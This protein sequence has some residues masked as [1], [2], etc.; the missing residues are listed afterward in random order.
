MRS[1]SAPRLWP[2]AI[3]FAASGAGALIVETVWMRWLRDWL[4]ATAPAAAAASTAYFAGSALGAWLGA[5][6]A[7]RL[8]DRRAALRAYA[9][10]ELLAALGAAATPLLL[11]VAGAAF[12]GG[13]DTLRETRSL[14]VAARFA[15]SLVVTFPAAVAY[16]ATLPLIGAA[17][18]PSLAR[19]G[20]H[21]AALYAANLVGAACGVAVAAWW[22]PGLLGVDGTYAIGIVLALSASASAHRLAR[23]ESAGATDAPARDRPIHPP[24]RAIV[25]AALSGFVVLGVQVLLV[26]AFALVLHRP[27]V[28]F[29]AVL[30]A[31][32]LC[33]SGGAWIVSLLR[34][35]GWATGEAIAAWSLVG[36]A[37]GAAAIPAAVFAVTPGAASGAADASASPWRAIAT[38]LTAAAPALV[39]MGCVWPAALASCADDAAGGDRATIGVYVGELS[40]ANTL[41][42]IAGGV[43]APFVLLP[44]CGPWT[45][46]A[47][48]AAVCAVAGVALP[49]TPG[50]SRWPRA[51]AAIVGLGLVVIVASPFEP[52][53]SRRVPGSAVLFERATPSGIVS[54]VES[55][56]ERRIRVDDHYSLGGTAETVHE[57]RQ[58]HLPLLLHAAPRRVA[59][60]GTATGI[61]ASA[62]LAHDVDEVTL[63]EI[64]PEVAT[65]AAAYFDDANRG[66][67]RDDRSRVVLDDARNYL[68]HTSDDFDVIVSDLFVPWRAGALYSREHFEAVRD[69]LRPGGVAA[70]WLPLYQLSREELATIAATFND[71]FPVSAA[72]RGDFY[73][74][75]PI[76]ALVGWRDAVARA[77]DVEAAVRRL[78]RG[79]SS[80]R[81]MSDPVAFWST[82]V[83]PLEAS[84]ESTPR[85]T[86]TRPRIELSAAPA[87][88]RRAAGA[89]PFVG[90]AWT[91][92]VGERQARL[93]R[94]PDPLYPDLGPGADR[95]RR[96]GSALQKANALFAS[97]RHDE[98]AR[99]LA[100]AS[101]LLPPEMLAP[102]RPDRSAS[103]VWPSATRPPA[104]RATTG[105]SPR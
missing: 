51:T 19:L 79:D 55:A 5:R 23:P 1:R 60:V 16:G 54:V 75:H 33:L 67:Y 34:T 68:R 96:G 98:A 29:G 30:I 78:A 73:G 6:R 31:V 74:E 66:I 64:V 104:D 44:W 84:P 93:L 52:P 14:L 40:L 2:L 99:A 97:G 10:V 89:E 85:N 39:A 18:V 11:L 94:G 61:T 3:V 36:S 48:A 71:V 88:Q 92:W 32:L 12:A 83:S 4:G 82:Y 28:A 20:S 15:V 91:R 42:A 37:I 80:D 87:A 35:R 102:D 26:Q 27:V 95:A 43:A 105:A 47:V 69:R 21:G 72:F 22:G 100:A 45:A 38:V 7:R 49:T 62:A 13:Y 25:A 57:R 46:F 63:V 76:V 65:A 53:L 103:D 17:A 90:L 70:Q 50:S 81:W 58:G 9:G 8:R 101:T 41:G 86:L 77:D 56:G 24:R 59:F